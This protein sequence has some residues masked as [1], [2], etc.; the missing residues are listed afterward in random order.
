MFALC[1]NTIKSNWRP[2]SWAHGACGCFNALII[3]QFFSSLCATNLNEQWNRCEYIY[4][5]E[6]TIICMEHQEGQKD[7]KFHASF[8]QKLRCW[9]VK[10]R[11][12]LIF[13]SLCVLT[14][15]T[16]APVLLWT[17]E[18]I[19][20]YNHTTQTL[21]EFIK[22]HFLLELWAM[23][24]FSWRVPLV[25]FLSKQNERAPAENTDCRR[26]KRWEVFI[27]AALRQWTVQQNIQNDRRRYPNWF[28]T[29][30]VF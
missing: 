16:A 3:I 22:S 4:L 8:I 2:Y 6:Q 12:P 29:I 25:R 28:L 15:I 19:N 11:N 26:R 27:C 21:Y 17:L 20:L 23:A 10:T 14:G 24:P 13:I 5:C 9:D 7:L 18:I 1:C 30:R